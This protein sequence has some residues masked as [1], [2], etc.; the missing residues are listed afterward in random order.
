MIDPARLSQKT[1]QLQ[2]EFHAGI[3][4]MTLDVTRCKSKN[5]RI[6]SNRECDHKN[7]LRVLRDRPDAVGHFR[8]N[9]LWVTRKR[10]SGFAEQSEVVAML[11]G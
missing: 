5:S 9:G 8:M 1:L 4:V 6:Y 7:L 2:T 11:V 3:V 10:G